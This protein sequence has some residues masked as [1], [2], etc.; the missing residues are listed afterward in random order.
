MTQ[1]KPPC[2]V[3]CDESCACTVAAKR[4][5]ARR[6]AQIHKEAQARV[7]SLEEEKYGSLAPPSPCCLSSRPFSPF[8]S[9]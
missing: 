6:A 3:S 1:P 2:R 9:L 7:A 8:L 5:I 4:E